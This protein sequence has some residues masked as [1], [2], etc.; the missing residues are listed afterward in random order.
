MVAGNRPNPDR[1]PRDDY[2]TDPAWTRVLL[3]N[4]PLVGPVWECAA[5][6]GRM[7]SVLA[8]HY[9]TRVTDIS[10][11][12]DFLA[13]TDRAPSIVTNPPYRLLDQFIE[14]GLQQTDRYLCLLAGWHSLAGGQR[15][16]SS[17]WRRT[18]PNRA[19]A[20]P[21]R[22]KVGGAPSQFNHVWL[23]WDLV[24]PPPTHPALSWHSV[25]NTPETPPGTGA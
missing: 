6:E 21:E 1:R 9:P 22:M 10:T 15:R 24:V 23:V 7:A 4:Q 20:I 25:L 3:L 14:H 13:S 2:P 11:G 12:T 5:G 18:P 16:A 8:Q 17:I 19:L